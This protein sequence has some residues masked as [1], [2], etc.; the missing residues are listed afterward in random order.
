MSQRVAVITGAGRGIGA[1]VAELLAEQGLAVVVNDLGTALDGSGTDPG[2]AAEVAERIRIAGGRAIHD[3]GDV[4]DHAA[5]GRLVQR[6]FE[7]FGRL[8]VLVNVAGILRDRMIFNMT[9]EEWDAVIRVHLRGT[10][11]TTKHAAAAW[12]AAPDPGAHRRVINFT[13]ISGLRGAAGQPNYAAAKMGIVGLTYS[14]ANALARFG[15]TAN[16]VSPGAVTRMTD[17]MPREKR[18]SNLAAAMTPENVAP[19]VGYLASEASH[20][21]TG[22]VV[23]AEGLE[24]GLYNRPEQIRTVRSTAPWT[25]EGI[26]GAIESSFRPAVEGHR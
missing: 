24:I 20:W 22:Q 13:S 16:A 6:A 5:A 17:T 21:L 7:E 3:T 4:S 1:G 26:A 12:R 2:P 18:A 19:L 25:A 15:V 10:F 11:S 8:D 9:E 23:S 14:C